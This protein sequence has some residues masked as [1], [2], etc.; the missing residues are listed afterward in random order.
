MHKLKVWQA[1]HNGLKHVLFNKEL[2]E[3]GELREQR[4]LL[5]QSVKNAN[6][7]LESC[8]AKTTELNKS[9]DQFKVKLADCSDKEKIPL[10]YQ[11]VAEELNKKYPQVS[12]THDLPILIKDGNVVNVNVKVQNF[13]GEFYELQNK[14][15]RLGFTLEAYKQKYSEHEWG[16][17]VNKLAFDIYKHTRRYVKYKYDVNKYGFNE[18]W[19]LPILTHYLGEG[20]CEDSSNLLL[21]WFKAAGLPAFALRNTCGM[22]KLGGHSTV[23]V[24]D[25]KNDVWR[26]MEATSQTTRGLK[27]FYSLPSKKKPHQLHIVDVWWSFN[28]ENAWHKFETAGARKTMPKRFTIEAVA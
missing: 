19:Q 16:E 6:Q 15:K 11:G 22:T 20:D 26:H 7:K 21:S 9:I 3:L 18:Y 25:F 17:L 2:R 5:R 28:W 8:N 27:N 24:Y 4:I 13:I 12:V 23:Y 1:L 10:E 14:V